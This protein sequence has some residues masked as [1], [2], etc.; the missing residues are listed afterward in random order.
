M[1]R[2]DRSDGPGAPEG[3][4]ST[5]ARGRG[6]RDD[7]AEAIERLLGVSVGKEGLARALQPGFPGLRTY[8]VQERS[9]TDRVVEFT[10]V[11]VSREGEPVYSGS[12]AIGLCRDG[13]LELHHGFDEVDPPFRS[14]NIFADSLERELAILT[15]LG[16]GPR[17]RLTADAE[18]AGRYVCALH[19]F[20]F[21]DETDQG[22]PVRTRISPGP[23]D[24]FRLVDFFVRFAQR[25]TEQR[26]SP[27]ELERAIAR[28]RACRAPLDFASVELEGIELQA[29]GESEIG[30]GRFGRSALCA[31]EAPAWRG[32]LYIG[33]PKHEAEAAARA[34]GRAFR[35]RLRKAHETKSAQEIEEALVALTGPRR[36][37]TRA[38]HTLARVATARVATSMRPIAEGPDRRLASVARRAM[39]EISNTRLPDLLRIYADDARHDPAR[40]ALAYRVLADYF[41]RKLDDVV[42]MLRVHPNARIAR[43]A[44]PLLDPPDLASMLAA[45]VDP[46]VDGKKPREGLLDLRI[47]LIERLAL[48]RDPRTIPVLVAAL[49]DHPPPSERLALTRALLASP[50]PRGRTALSASA[51]DLGSPQVP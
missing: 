43:A 16:R 44:A 8:V 21:A 3:V 14:R 34:F 46:P 40:R 41:P 28:A 42:T 27:L 9:A 37:K 12:R 20:I 35:E 13:S 48:A 50:D 36:Q 5:L 7:V 29:V 33:P 30:A 26:L 25:L 24:R 6:L 38:L 1:A 15:E 39:Q 19:G 22:P 11:G 51:F 10:V 2:Y 4:A 45:N 49:D 31:D 18:G 17:P 32:A 23:P 47:E